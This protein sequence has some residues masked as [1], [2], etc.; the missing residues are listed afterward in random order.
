MTNK[1]FL[2]II[3]QE[4]VN[5]SCVYLSHTPL[6]PYSPAQENVGNIYQIGIR[7]EGEEDYSPHKR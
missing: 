2:I 6:L 7:Q 3:S 5:Y 1:T 4:R